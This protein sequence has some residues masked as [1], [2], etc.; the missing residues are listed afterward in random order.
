MIL[1]GL[2]FVAVTWKAF[3]CRI[4]WFSRECGCD[5]VIKS[6]KLGSFYGKHVFT[7][8]C[9]FWCVSSVIKRLFIQI[10]CVSADFQG[11][12]LK[13]LLPR[14]QHKR[15]CCNRK[16]HSGAEQHHA[17]CEGVGPGRAQ[18][19]AALPGS[20]G[21]NLFHRFLPAQVQE[22]CILPWKGEWIPPLEDARACITDSE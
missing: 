4:I 18:H 3:G 9:I 19:R 15:H 2:L 10:L 16:Y 8:V 17:G 20:H 1:Q 21:W 12:P 7:L 11:P 13:T 22:Q 6:D 5:K 14:Q